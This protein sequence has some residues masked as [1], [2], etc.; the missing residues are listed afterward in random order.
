MKKWYV[1]LLLASHV[2]LIGGC[3]IEDKNSSDHANQISQDLTKHPI[4]KD[5]VF[6]QNE[7]V[8][9]IGDQPLWVPTSNISV[10]IRQDDILRQELASLGYRLEFHPFLKG[11]DINYFLLKGDLEVGIGGDMPALRAAS[12]GNVAVIS[13][14]QK[15]PVS[16][17]SRD[18]KEIKG[19]RGKKIAYAL[20]SN[21]HFYLLNTLTKN[22]VNISEVR[23]IQMDVTLMPEALH[24]GKI[25]A[26]SAWEPTPLMALE[27]Y[28]EF[29]IT[30]RGKSHGFLY[31]REELLRKHPEV[32]RHLLASEIRVLRWLKMSDHNLTISSKL[33]NNSS[34]KLSEKNMLLPVEKISFL[35]K[36]DLPGISI[37]IFPR[38]SPDLLS[39]HGV[40]KKEFELLKK[41]GFISPEKKWIDIKEK[42]D[43]KIL[44]TVISNPKKYRIYEEINIK[45]SSRSED[46]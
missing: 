17:V 21:A 9:D 46:R 28:P 31:V 36:R 38:I 6:S 2:L 22:R 26:F 35:A 20:G 4:Y 13:L 14:I 19:L 18:I 43:L 32:A 27:K 16:I 29:I 1:L 23:L 42:F 5:Y 41:L 39:D 30:H 40:L 12:T 37:K 24:E 34:L 8:I 3:E 11:N 44:E 45:N 33:V 7:N 10:I 25:D 15:G